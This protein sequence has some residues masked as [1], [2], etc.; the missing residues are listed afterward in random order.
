MESLAQGVIFQAR[1]TVRKYRQSD[2]EEAAR[3]GLLR[4]QPTWRQRRKGHAVAYTSHDLDRLGIDPYDQVEAE[5]NLMVNGATNTGGIN[6]M[7]NLLIGGAGSTSYANG[8]ARLCV[9][10]GGGSVPT[11]A[12]TD[13]ALAATSNRYNQAC[14]AASPSVASQVLTAI[15]VFATGNANWAWNEWGIDNGGSSGSGAASGLLNHKGV[16]LGTKT[17]ASA[18]T[19]TATIT[20]S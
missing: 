18:W 11:A 10:D 17:S 19:A 4:L 13:T 5:H 9:G 2:I 7:L 20:E 8:N 3:E 16:S 1:L 14:Q 6:T 15:S 12:A